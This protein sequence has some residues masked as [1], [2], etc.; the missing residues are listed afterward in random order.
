MNAAVGG[1]LAP[2]PA[3][4]ASRDLEVAL[5]VTLP[6]A[7]LVS[8]V[9]TPAA[10]GRLVGP[11]WVHV[12]TGFPCPTCGITR[13]LVALARGRWWAAFQ[14]QPLITIAATLAVLYMPWAAGVLA[15]GWPPLRIELR[16]PKRRALRWSIVGA[17]LINW[18][19]LIRAG[20]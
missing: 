12:L 18:A 9:S 2:S 20:V 15:R 7:A 14:V 5:L 4:R 16:G 8:S 13:A 6:A 3:R 19:Y 1:V 11:C 17:V 10:I